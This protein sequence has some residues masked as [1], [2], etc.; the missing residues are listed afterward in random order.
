M[1]QLNYQNSG[2][3]I[4][5]GNRAVDK[6]KQVVAET[7]NSQVLGQLGGFGGMFMPDL[8]G[9][10]RPV[11]VSGTDGVGTKLELAIRAKSYDTVGIDLVAMS[12]NDIITQG[13]KPLFFLD[14]I[15]T[16]KLKADQISQIVTGIAEGCR[17]SGCALIGGETAEMPGFYEQERF[18]L[19]GFCTGIVDYDNIIDGRTIQAG[20]VLIGLSSSGIHS[21]GYSL[22]RKLFFDHLQLTI[23]QAIPELGETVGECLLRPTKIY[24]QPVLEILDKVTVKGMVHVTGGGFIENIPRILPQGLGVD[25]H[26]DSWPMPKIFDYMMERGNI[27]E[28]EM[29]RT[30]NMGI[31]YILVVDREAGATVLQEL[32][33]SYRIGQVVAGSGVHLVRPMQSSQ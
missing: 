33:D 16:G 3:N 29:F 24:V 2:V 5:E 8:T 22:V 23:D 32:T 4:S 31:G 26:L 28:Q 9:F 12:V 14:Y 7:Y 6:I 17:Q 18:D 13:A 1:E 25:I 21:N 20:D 19:A 10:K 15:A 27:A 30:F 11:L